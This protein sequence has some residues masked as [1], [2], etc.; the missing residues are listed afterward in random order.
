MPAG[1]ET[2]ANCGRTIG[3]L[4]TPHLHQEHVVCPECYAR[5]AVPAASAA[6]KQRAVPHKKINGLLIAV[7]VATIA[8]AVIGAIVLRRSRPRPPVGRIAGS[9]CTSRNDGSSDLQRGLQVSVIWGPI[10][11]PVLA[12]CLQREI[13]KWEEDAAQNKSRATD[14]LTGWISAEFYENEAR[15]DR[16]KVEGIKGVISQLP[17]EMGVKEA[18]E[19][20][21]ASV[22]SGLPA[23]GDVIIANSVAT[24]RTDA[25][26][27]YTIE[28]VPEGDYFLFAEIETRSFLR[29][30]LVPVHVTA[31]TMT[32]VDLFDDNA[33]VLR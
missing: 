28:S 30:W 4:E 15:K 12:Q 5:L 32:K 27:R 29:Q 26:G 16:E 7:I 25:D 9:A 8:G 13:E 11:R 31:G 6:S 2:C 33:A 21:A 14:R 19:F 23:F 24:G 20:L 3:N 22:L 18:D 10:R 1:L 17:A